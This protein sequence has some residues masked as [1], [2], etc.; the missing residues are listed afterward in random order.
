LIRALGAF[1][2]VNGD[3][4]QVPHPGAEL[5]SWIAS[6]GKNGVRITAVAAVLPVRLRTVHNLD[7]KGPRGGRTTAARLHVIGG[8]V[9]VRD[10]RAEVTLTPEADGTRIHWAATWDDTFRGRIVRRGLR[11]LYPQIVAA[12]VAAAEQSAGARRT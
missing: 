1:P 5:F 11:D 6:A 8:G 2:V 9:P 7:R 3:G 10:Y 4:Q 12:L